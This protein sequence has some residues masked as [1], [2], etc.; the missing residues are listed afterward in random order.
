MDVNIQGKDSVTVINAYAPTSS[1]EDEK[2][3]H[4][5]MILKEQCLIVTPNTRP[6]QE[7]SMQ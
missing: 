3:N 6:L 1:A 4:C 5:M 2:W 7:I